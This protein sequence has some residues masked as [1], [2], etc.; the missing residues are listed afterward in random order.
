MFHFRVK[1]QFDGITKGLSTITALVT[2]DYPIFFVVTF[3]M[4]LQSC[5]V[6]KLFGAMFTPVFGQ[7]EVDVI[8]VKVHQS[9]GFKFFAALFAGNGSRGMGREVTFEGKFTFKDFPT[10]LA[11][12]RRAPFCWL[13]LLLVMMIMLL[14]IVEYLKMLLMILVLEI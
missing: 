5:R 12:K 9:L 3:D 4:S 14:L 6:G 13:L 10:D 1:Y 7:L 2:N 11:G 8:P